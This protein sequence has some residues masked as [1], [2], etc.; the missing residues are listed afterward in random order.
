MAYAGGTKLL[1]RAAAALVIV[2]FAVMWGLLL[3]ENLVVAPSRP[4]HIDY[5][6][7][8]KPDE[9]ERTAA[10]GMY[11]GNRKVGRTEVRVQRT[12]DGFIETA[13]KTN[14]ELGAWANVVPGISGSYDLSFTT[15]VSPLRGLQSF[16]AGSERL[17]ADML[18]IVSKGAIVLQGHIG[19]RKVKSRIPYGQGRLLGPALSPIA[20]LP[21]LNPNMV[22]RNWRLDV[23]NPLL[24]TLHE[25]NVEIVRADEMEIGGASA[26]VYQLDFSGSVGDWRS[27]VTQ[28]GWVLVQGTPFGLVLRD[29]SLTPAELQRLR[30]PESDGTVPPRPAG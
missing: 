20:E 24:G 3:R 7:I 13:T 30:A 23:V 1:Y 5:A 12:E 6:K 26:T 18:G 10:W 25:V 14:V 21:E 16:Q 15:T 29:E 8:L 9:K 2:F 19:N 28:D 27:W 17:N 4:I 11:V 22:G